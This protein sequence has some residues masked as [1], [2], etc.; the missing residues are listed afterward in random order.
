MSS[1]GWG[2]SF[3]VA[4]CAA[5]LVGACAHADVGG[6]A[7][8]AKAAAEPKSE[9]GVA[10]IT[11]TATS[12]GKR[13]EKKPSDDAADRPTTLAPSP[14][15]G[16]SPAGASAPPAPPRPESESTRSRAASLH[17]ARG[18]LE[19]ARRELDLSMNDCM[20]ACRAL[21]SMER[22]TGHLCDLASET[23]DRQR[24]EDAKTAVQKA[25]ERI[26]GTC[27]SCPNGPSLDKTAP[28]P[29]R[30]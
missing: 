24:C 23:D 17:A 25:R 8:P 6:A 3:A 10:P 15:S 5:A 7:P 2:R 22:A 28:I 14:G 20:S 16:V 29:S 26:R 12:E 11:A 9:L 18:E 4:A 13:S 1:R 27:R 19:R 21:G 30:P